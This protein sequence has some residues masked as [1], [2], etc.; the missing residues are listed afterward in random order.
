MRKFFL[1]STLI[2]G[3]IIAA[4]SSGSYFLL[5]NNSPQEVPNLP[6]MT[7]ELS[8]EEDIMNDITINENDQF[9]VLVPETETVQ[10]PI[11]YAPEYL[12][13]AIH[14]DLANY[15]QLHVCNASKEKY[16][17]YLLAE[18]E[19][20][21][22][23]PTQAYFD[24]R[25]DIDGELMDILFEEFDNYTGSTISGNNQEVLDFLN[26]NLSP[27]FPLRVEQFDAYNINFISARIQPSSRPHV[28]DCK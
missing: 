27:A 15:A 2:G 9:D 26:E 14:T 13:P 10:T 23:T 7:I 8:A 25:L 22:A 19:M 28:F 16:E 12:Q 5:V 18:I 21:K 24:Q 4:I 6:D 3:P 17:L 1:Y 20:I 11:E